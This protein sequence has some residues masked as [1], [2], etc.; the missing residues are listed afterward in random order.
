[1][2]RNGTRRKWS[3]LNESLNS[4]LMKEVHAHRA[5]ILVQEDVMVLLSKV[6]AFL[7]NHVASVD[8]GHSALV[9]SL[10]IFNLFIQKRR[11]EERKSFRY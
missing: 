2:G 9:G 3:G 6:A 10:Q 8:D 11:S 5:H 1:M 7:N 4:V